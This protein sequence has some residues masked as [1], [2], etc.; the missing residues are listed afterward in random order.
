MLC[1]NY[2]SA[3]SVENGKAETLIFLHGLLG[4]GSDWNDVVSELTDYNILTIDLPGHGGSRAVSCDGFE[5]CC[6]LIQDAIRHGLPEKKGLPEEK[7]QQPLFLIG[8]SLGARIMMYG[9]THNGFSQLNIGGGVIEGGNFGLD[10]EQ[11]KQTRF[12]NDQA[13][14]R[15]F[16]Q[17]S[18]EQVLF[19]WYGQPVFSSLNPEQKQHMVQKR[20]H[21]QGKAVADMLLATSLAKQ[22]YL[23]NQLRQCDI[24]V[25]YLCG[26]QDKKFSELAK[27]SGLSFTCVENA[28]HNA[29][30]D[31]PRHYATLI[32]TIVTQIQTKQLE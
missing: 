29:H 20:S 32:R 18:I 9:L 10:S 16:Q 22:P 4:D 3:T 2:T 8:Y 25:H 19:A 11:E 17:E 14:A 30:S 1:A 6:A 24:P 7:P 15:R 12:I 26:T 5:H 13:W 27:Q 23:L 21:N 28:G 31:Q